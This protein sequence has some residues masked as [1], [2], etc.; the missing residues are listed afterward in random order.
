M[1]DDNMEFMVTNWTLRVQYELQKMPEAVKR[2]IDQGTFS[3]KNGSY[4]FCRLS[5][6]Q[7]CPLQAE[8]KYEKKFCFRMQ[9]HAELEKQKI[10]L[11]NQKAQ[12]QKVQVNSID[13]G[14]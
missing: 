9:Y 3:L 12:V 14:L 6:S 7:Y 2:C 11:G 8:C 4:D 13:F 5:E 1:T 10:D